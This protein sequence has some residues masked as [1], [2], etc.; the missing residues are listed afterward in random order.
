MEKNVAAQLAKRAKT[1]DMQAF[2]EL[3]L[4]HEEFVY[5]IVYRIVG[6]EQDAWDVSQETFLRVY[7][8]LD[9]FDGRAA[10]S[11][12]LY[13]I[14][15]NAAIDLT[16]RRKNVRELPLDGMAGEEEEPAIQH[17]DPA[18]SPEEEA[19]NQELRQKLAQAVQNLPEDYRWAVILRDWESLSYQ[20]IAD[21][22]GLP[23]GTVKSRVSRGRLWLRNA[24]WEEREPF[25]GGARHKDE[26][27]N[28][29]EG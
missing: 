2:E 1:G 16:R 17:V 29:R 6:N 3:V 7:Q 10:F 12:W 20:E 18:P 21:Q 9:R 15:H 5:R 27:R 26:N 8:N 19:L 23:L 14:A 25:S 4:A 13:R 22:L 11:T 24:L 28:G